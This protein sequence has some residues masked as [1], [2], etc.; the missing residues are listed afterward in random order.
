MSVHK[1]VS[2]V[3]VVTLTTAFVW[4]SFWTAPVASSADPGTIAYVQRSTYDIHVIAPD[5]SGDRVLW[6]APDPLGPWPADDLAWRP[7]GRELAFSS[8]HEVACSWYQSDVY[9]I[10]YNGGG[11]RRVTNA[12]AC[13]LLAG[14]PKGS[15]TV[16]VTN[17]TNSLVQA[18][19][20]GAPEPQSIPANSYG[21]VTFH[22]VAD[23]GPG[24]PQP[25]VGIYGLYRFMQSAPI[26]DVQ[27]NKTVA[28][29]YLNFSNTRIYAFGAGKVSWKADGSAL[30]YGMRTSSGIDQI[31]ANPP[32]GSIGVPLPVVENASPHLV[33]WGPTDAS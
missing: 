29:G 15:V 17:G 13:A 2:L 26:A 11:Y 21:T 14:L 22:N 6:T 8:E 30:A 32:Y 3:V 33:A 12:P 7:D 9:A 19:V 18:Y 27:P 16:Q 20:A 24:V 25:S 1:V 31:P 10:R 4:A 28:G 23:F 5:G